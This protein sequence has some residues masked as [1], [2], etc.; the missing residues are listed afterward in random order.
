MER[1]RSVNLNVPKYLR[2][3]VRVPVIHGDLSKC[4]NHYAESVS[5]ESG[6]LLPDTE[7]AEDLVGLIYESNLDSGKSCNY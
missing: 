5:R 4:V 7:I 3:P 2:N 1:R 6:G